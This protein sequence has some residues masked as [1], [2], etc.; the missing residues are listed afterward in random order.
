MN[1]EELYDTLRK[2]AQV[3]LAAASPGPEALELVKKM[4]NERDQDG[5]DALNIT[6]ET[7]ATHEEDD[8][9][10][11]YSEVFFDE[12]SEGEEDDDN[13]K[14]LPRIFIDEIDRRLQINLG[15]EPDSPPEDA[16]IQ[17]LRSYYQCETYTSYQLDHHKG[18]LDQMEYIGAASQCSAKDPLVYTAK[19]NVP[20]QNSQGEL[21]QKENEHDDRVRLIRYRELIDAMSAKGIK[22]GKDWVLQGSRKG[23]DDECVF[24]MG[25]MK[26]SMNM[27][28]LIAFGFSV[29]GWYQYVN[30]D[31]EFAC[32]PHELRHVEMDGDGVSL[33]NQCIKLMNRY[34]DMKC[35]LGPTAVFKA[36]EGGSRG[37]KKKKTK[38]KKNKGKDGKV[39]GWADKSHFEWVKNK[40]TPLLN[41][42]EKNSLPTDITGL[43]IFQIGRML[44]SAATY[45]SAVARALVDAGGSECGSI[46]LKIISK[47]IENAKAA[48]EEGVLMREKVWLSAHDFLMRALV[49]SVQNSEQDMS[50]FLFKRMLPQFTNGLESSNAGER[51]CALY[52]LNSLLTGAPSSFLMRFMERKGSWARIEAACRISLED[53]INNNTLGDNIDPRDCWLHQN[54]QRA[55]D[56]ASIFLNMICRRSFELQRTKACGDQLSPTAL[57]LKIIKRGAIP[58]LMDIAK[59]DIGRASVAAMHSLSDI[60]RVKDCRTIMYQDEAGLDLVKKGLAT[61]DAE[62]ISATLLLIVHLLWDQEEWSSPISSIEPGLILTTIR[63]GLFAMR[64]IIKRAE[65]RKEERSELSFKDNET[66]K[67][68]DSELQLET[69]K[70]FDRLDQLLMRCLITLQVVSKIEGG[71]E[72]FLLYDGLSFISSCID[73]RISHTVEAAIVAMRNAYVVLGMKAIVPSNF[74]DPAHYVRELFTVNACLLISDQTK[75]VQVAHMLRQLQSQLREVSEWEF[76]FEQLPSNVKMMVDLF[77]PKVSEAQRPPTSNGNPNAKCIHSA[78]ESYATHTGKLRSCNGCGKLETK[79]G[80]MSKCSGC[81]QVLYCSREVSYFWTFNSCLCAHFHL[82]HGFFFY[83]SPTVSSTSLAQRP[84]EGMQ[85]GQQIVG[86]LSGTVEKFMSRCP[87]TLAL[88]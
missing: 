65:V 30:F 71:L 78:A 88:T 38:G 66:E 79:R 37:A 24:D 6:K 74:Y 28:Q 82:A 84:Q 13:N 83:C 55:L 44:Q 72:H 20:P 86:Q 31:I 4:L 77:T 51:A 33:I 63:W 61:N 7:V 10:E 16:V 81:Y 47:A 85:E 69:D 54:R 39:E 67:I 8:D 70:N 36:E 29:F 22:V 21:H 42:A 5:D 26:D 27:Q 58:L 19:Y 45:D 34:E 52:N 46:V 17:A 60:S 9:D 2:L 73:I 56:R 80:S 23:F 87:T 1:D 68:P 15:H 3:Q 49:C 62:L 11:D 75:R 12:N 14:R 64:E 57:A 48:K 41:A 18:Y 53:C 25:D 59:A 40:L 32:A 35:P 50:T 43:F 76:Y